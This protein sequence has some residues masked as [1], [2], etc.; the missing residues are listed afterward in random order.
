[1]T[2]SKQASLLICAALLLLIAA[3]PMQAQSASPVFLSFTD[4]VNGA[5]PAKQ[6]ITITN[7]T[8][9]VVTSTTQTGGNWLS[10]STTGGSGNGTIDVTATTGNLAPGSYGGTIVVTFS[11]DPGNARSI[12]VTF[13]VVNSFM[14]FTGSQGGANP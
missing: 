3:V 1:M 8:T 7:T 14:S 11:N 12:G 4:V 9:W 10:L 5:G 13:D 2:T 6:T